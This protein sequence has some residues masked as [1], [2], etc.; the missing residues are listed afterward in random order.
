MT[1]QRGLSISDVA[2]QTGLST[3]VLRK[4]EREGLLLSEVQRDSC[5]RRIY[6]PI[7]VEWLCNCVKLRSCGMPLPEIRRY[8]CLVK[9][10]P[11][12]ERERLTVLQDQR[13]RLH[14]KIA[15]LTS[16]LTLLDHKVALYEDHLDR[17]KTSA[18]WA[19]PVHDS[20]I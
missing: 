9:K 11:G 15:E 3:H 5:G 20:D 18:P 2:A 7:D 4:Y 16:A 19:E 8:V 10:G 1:K 13:L 14:R 17:G 6:D 12:N